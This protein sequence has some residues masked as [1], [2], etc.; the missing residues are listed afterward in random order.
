MVPQS[1]LSINRASR[2][3]ATLPLAGTWCRTEGATGG[4]FPLAMSDGTGPPGAP[5]CHRIAK[6]RGGH[7]AAFHV[8]FRQH[9]VAENQHALAARAPTAWARKSRLFE[10]GALMKRNMRSGA[11]HESGS[12]RMKAALV[13]EQTPKGYENRKKAFGEARNGTP[14]AS[15]LHV[16]GVSSKIGN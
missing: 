8:D 16:F 15:F 2:S 4:V 12:G 11:R 9:G 13:T 7:G 6:G 14:V 1:P 10:K 3:E 5:Q